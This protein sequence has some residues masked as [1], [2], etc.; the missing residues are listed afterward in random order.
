M[1]RLSS[2]VVLA[3]GAGCISLWAQ[4]PGGSAVKKLD[5]A[6]DQIISTNATLEPLKTDY[7][8]IAEG[9]VWIQEGQNGYLLM[10]D[11]GGNVLYKWTPDN[12]LSVFLDKAGWTGANN[13]DLVGYVSASDHLLL[14]NIGPNGMTVDP[15]GRV[16]FVTQGDRTVVR[17]EKDGTR[18]VLADRFEGKRLNRP[19]DLAVK[20]DGW[21]YFTD[22]FAANNPAMVLPHSGVYRVKESNSD[23]QLLDKDLFPNGLTFSPDERILYVNGDGQIFRYDVQANGTLTNRRVFIDPRAS[24]DKAPGGPDGMKVDRAGNL[25]SGGP[26][27]LWIISPAGKHLGTILTPRPVTNM[28]FGDADGKTLYITT[29]RSLWKIRLN[30]PGITPGIRRQS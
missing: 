11:I 12:T 4:A 3:V 26:G 27:G 7:F 1:K 8:G 10:S 13:G 15:Q 9:P 18:T 25:Y 5:P 30:A 19:N 21:V 17:L 23:L 14:A 24:G 22:R 6:L 20:S 2:F 16:V 28:A 29:R